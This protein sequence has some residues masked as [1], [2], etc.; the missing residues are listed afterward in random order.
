MD[1]FLVIVRARDRFPRSSVDR[2]INGGS[3]RGRS[4]AIDNEPEESCLEGGH[5]VV[6]PCVVIASI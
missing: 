3:R 5:H 2:R 4:L 1:P 6:R